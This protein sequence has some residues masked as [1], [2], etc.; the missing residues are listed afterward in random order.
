MYFINLVV[1]DFLFG[2]VSMLFYVVYI[3]K[4]YSWLFGYYF[5]KMYMVI[6]FVLCLEFILMI[7]VISFDCLLFFWYGLYYSYKEILKI[8]VLKLVLMWI[9]VVFL[10]LL[11]IIGWD[12]WI[13]EDSVE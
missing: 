5:C 4:S 12:L 13:G 8:V 10:Y 11:V 1:I 3:F 9:V 7:I 6:D 2:L